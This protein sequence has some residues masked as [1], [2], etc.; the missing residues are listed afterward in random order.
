V[1]IVPWVVNPA[2]NGNPA[3]ATG[4]EHDLYED[5]TDLSTPNGTCPLAFFSLERP[6]HDT[7]N[8]LRI[9]YESPM[10]FH[11]NESLS[12]I[13]PAPWVVIPENFKIKEGE[14]W[15]GFYSANLS[16][17]TVVQRDLLSKSL[18]GKCFQR[19]KSEVMRS[20]TQGSR[21]GTGEEMYSTNSDDNYA[22][23]KFSKNH[24]MQKGADT[25]GIVLLRRPLRY[26]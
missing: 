25:G 7:F 15:T 4:E 21:N 23:T 3:G 11:L 10:F 16:L 8:T 13:W 14:C 19:L 2:V 12:T 6:E 20:W 22:R 1:P 9:D 18:K 17:K 26:Y 5:L 24:A